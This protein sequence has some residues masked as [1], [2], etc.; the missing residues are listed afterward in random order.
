ML[1]ETET[2]ADQEQKSERITIAITPT[3]LA[4]LEVVCRVHGTTYPGVSSC[5]RD[6][7]L[8]AAVAFAAQVRRVG[9][10]RE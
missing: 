9:L 3:E 5:L 6:F 8:R 2:V 10:G 4:A 1:P 7:S